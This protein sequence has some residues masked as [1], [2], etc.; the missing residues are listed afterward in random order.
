MI[1]PCAY[2]SGI[3]VLA[4]ISANH[5]G[6]LF[7]AAILY[8]FFSGGLM[9]LPPAVLVALSPSL[10]QIGVRVGMALTIG[11]LGVLIGSPIAGAILK[12]QSDTNRVGQE[13]A[14]DFSGTLAFTGV[15]L[16]LCGALMTVA[17]V[18]KKGFKF[19]KV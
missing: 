19:E 1:V 15:M 4:W 11:S 9:A 8:S 17:R 5:I 18:N 12:A 10:N 13:G 2:L 7:A 14:L 6:N 16:L 3:I